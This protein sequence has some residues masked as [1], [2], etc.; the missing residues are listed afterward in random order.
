M[1]LPLPTFLP[2]MSAGLVME[3]S[4]F[5]FRIATVAS[6]IGEEKR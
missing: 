4:P 5:F 2:A 3:A 1:A 6:A